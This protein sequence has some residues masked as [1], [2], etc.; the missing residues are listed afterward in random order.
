MDWKSNFDAEALER[1]E[2]IRNFKQQVG[3]PL[4]SDTEI[5]AV[6]A[7]ILDN[8]QGI[9]SKGCPYP[10]VAK[11]LTGKPVEYQGPPRIKLG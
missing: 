4:G 10:Y 6:M 1:I 9:I 5:I 3:Y 11:P 7:D 8:A 2:G